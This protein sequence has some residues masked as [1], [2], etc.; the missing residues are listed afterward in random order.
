MG[1]S[2]QQ[3]FFGFIPLCFFRTGIVVERCASIHIGRRARMAYRAHFGRRSKYQTCDIAF[4]CASKFR[5]LRVS[6][7]DT[8]IG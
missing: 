3:L 1:G 6:S 7:A 4:W 8:C 2:R 5:G